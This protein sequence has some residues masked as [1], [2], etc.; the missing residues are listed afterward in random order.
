MISSLTFNEGFIGK[1]SFKIENWL[2]FENYYYIHDHST[3]HEALICMKKNKLDWLTIVD[4]NL[5]PIGI[6]RSVDL[7]IDALDDSNKPIRDLDLEK[8]FNII[9]ADSTIFDIDIK[10]TPYHIVI[11][12]NNQFSGVLNYDRLIDGI[13]KQIE[14]LSQAEYTAEIL[15]IILES[16]YEGVA[17]VNEEGIILEFNEAYSRFTGIKKKD[18]VGRHV[19]EVIDNTNLHNTVKTGLPERGVIQY[20]QGQAMIVHRIPIWKEDRVIGAIGMLIFEG[21]TE[22]YRIY[23]RLQ[24]SFIEVNKNI[25]VEKSIDYRHIPKRIKQTV[26]LDKIIGASKST[27]KSKHLAREVAKTKVPVLITGETGT[28]KELYAQSIHNLSSY[29]DGHF[30]SVNCAAIPQELFESEIFGY[31]EGAF[32]GARKGGKPG[33]LELA[34]NGTL[35]LDEIAEMP[36]EMQSKLLRVLQEKRYERV[37]GTKEKYMNCRIIAATNR[38]IPEMITEGKFRSDLYYRLN[39]IEITIDPLRKR[40]EDIPQLLSHHL[41]E[42]CQEYDYP[43]KQ[44]TPK[45]MS[46]LMHYRWPGNVRELINTVKRLVI[47]VKDNYI[48]VEHLKAYTNILNQKN[49]SFSKNESELLF[50]HEGN[51]NALREKELIKYTLERTKGNKSKAARLLGIHRTTLYKKIKKYNIDK[52]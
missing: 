6:L 13:Q 33:K 51:L 31:E 32:T 42:T 35:F 52:V 7:L 17:V 19:T 22:V 36:Y 26:T 16:A 47:L 38:N 20:I 44:I 30:V 1:N 12:E 45:A 43:L 50:E 25:S 11:D 27:A 41:Y 46:Y 29:S 48:D 4:K 28:G 24:K 18:A 10:S 8:Q 5:Y 23:E 39:V 15:K 49:N 14:R 40:I 9:K 34:Q 21:V 2:K 3:V 37:G